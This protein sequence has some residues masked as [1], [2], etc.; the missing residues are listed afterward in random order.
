MGSLL[1]FIFT[2]KPFGDLEVAA[3]E[4]EREDDCAI[5]H[6]S[7]SNSMA[8]ALIALHPHAHCVVVAVGAGLRIFDLKNNIPIT[9]KDDIKH[10]GHG[11]VIRALKFE[12]EG[13]FLAT[14]GDDKKVKFWN[15]RSFQCI[16]TIHSSKKV[17]AITFS[18]CSQYLMFADKFGVVYVVAIKITEEGD[19]NINPEPVQLFGHCCSIITGLECSPEMKFVISS[20][21]D[22]KIRVSDFPKEPTLGAHEI[23]TFCLG[24][25]NFVSCVAFL[26]K[27]EG[28]ALLVSGGGDSTIR[29]WDY[30]TGNLHD[31]FVITMLTEQSGS[32]E[33]SNGTKSTASVVGM[34]VAPSGS[35]LA[36]LSERLEGVLLLRCDFLAKKLIFMQKLLFE[37]HT[38]PTSLQFDQAG[39]IWVVAGAAATIDL[40]DHVL[41]PEEITMAETKA[42]AF[43]LAAFARVIIVRSTVAISPTD[44]LHARVDGSHYASI[45]DK[46]VPG[47][48]RLLSTLQGSQADLT[49]AMCAAEAAKLSMKNLLSKRQF[50][51]EQRELRKCKRSDRILKGSKHNSLQPETL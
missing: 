50:S 22:F 1:N 2:C 45:Q 27:D 8:P 40:G 17:S 41:T 48:E 21:R 20:D 35:V 43:S 28:K 16:K 26:G 44:H 14:A 32:C 34:A 49:I 6:H 39:N 42:Q 31:T 30:Q 29:L 36:A 3:M 15:T 37:E 24:H 51:F 33:E 46:D 10:I 25:T 9:T 13:K 38:C 47:G 19:E 12:K 7:S 11:G 18:H 23:H 5:Q 4:E